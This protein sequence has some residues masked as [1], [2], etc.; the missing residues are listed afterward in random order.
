MKKIAILATLLI[1]LNLFAQNTNPGKPPI[2]FKTFKNWASVGDGTVSNNGRF[3]CYTI[4]HSGDGVNKLIIEA[5]DC[6]WKEEFRDG[7]SPKFTSDNFY[8][9]FQLPGDTLALLNLDTKQVRTIARVKDFQVQ[10]YDQFH[11]IIYRQPKTKSSLIVY[12]LRSNEERRYDNTTDFLVSPNGKVLLMKVDSGPRVAL[13][14]KKLP[15]DKITTIWTN[16][17]ENINPINFVFDSGA[18]QIAFLTEQHAGIKPFYKL[19]YCKTFDGH[20][21]KIGDNESMPYK[22]DCKMT[23]KP[24]SFS[25]DG[26][27][28]FFY[29]EGEEPRISNNKGVQVDVW[30]Y[31]DPVLQSIQLERKNRNAVYL[32]SF[33][34]DNNSVIQLQNGGEEIIAKSN[35]Y[36]LASKSGYAASNASEYFWNDSAKFDYYLISTKTGERRLIEGNC[37]NR[38]GA[39]TLSPTG[40][41]IIYY[42]F[43]AKNYFSYEVDYHKRRKLFPEKHVEFTDKINETPEKVISAAPTW[44]NN[45]SLVVISDNYD[46]W[47]VDP[48]CRHDPINLTNGYGRRHHIKFQVADCGET[49]EQVSGL[50]ST[51]LISAFDTETKNNGFYSIKPGIAQNPGICSMGPFMFG[52][53]DGYHNDLSLIKAKKNKSFLVMRMSASDSPNYFFTH[54]FKTFVRLTDLEPQQ[55]YNWLS[56]TLVHW[57]MFDGH[58]GTGMLYKPENFDS[59]RKYPVIFDYYEDRSRELNVFIKPALSAGRINIPWFVS[60][61]YIVFVPD[62]MHR[63]SS[64]PGPTAYNAVVSAA[65][66][67]SK[68]PWVN[69]RKMGIQGH[70]FGGYETYYL[71]THTHI[72]AAACAVSGFADLPSWYGSAARGGY[73][74][75]WAEESQGRLGDAPWQN[76]ALYIRNSPIFRVNRVTTPLLMI[77]NKDDDV[78]PFS[79]GVEFFTAMRRLGKKAWMLQYDGSA[80]AINQSE[81]FTIR[82]DQFF[83]YYL[84]GAVAPKWMVEGIPAKMKGIDDGLKLEPRSVAPG[85]G[86]TSGKK[87]T[88]F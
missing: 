78:V 25:P 9:I 20:A 35:D 66:Y 76:P 14:V 8:L 67:L 65:K 60:R 42:D 63:R 31:R 37:I 22:A 81:D 30:S 12:D 61:G 33:N 1:P 71:V 5:A 72:F 15:E 70:S 36:V 87:L 57:Q 59:R 11:F 6:N 27:H 83:D 24:L 40:K 13:K 79:Q 62:I 85:R 68:F 73:P 74:I 75:M 29:L 80:H 54:D 88:N 38:T 69:S 19:W 21:L 86:V 4:R 18:T 51:M 56:V 17:E 46:L 49:G 58:R 32:C 43:V 50:T 34:L 64:E 77:N 47:E 52:Y 23:D 28:I 26:K 7:Y 82:M 53:F 84:K 44:I 41:W 16:N 2:D 48:A 10:E 55:Q 3:I 45:D 39:P